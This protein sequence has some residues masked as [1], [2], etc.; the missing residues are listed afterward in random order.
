MA[1]WET[2]KVNDE[3]F[4]QLF[5]NRSQ[6]EID[7][8]FVQCKTSPTMGMRLHTESKTPYCDLCLENKRKDWT[9]RR[10]KKGLPTRPLAKCGTLAA[11]KRHYRRGEPLDR[12]CRKAFRKHC[13]SRKLGITRYEIAEIQG[14]HCYFCGCKLEDNEKTHIDHFYPVALGGSNSPHNLNLVC[15]TCNESKHSKDPFQ[16]IEERFGVTNG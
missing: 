7:P 8:M 9:E 2:Y 13:E 5:G 10:I 6:Y 3:E 14:W 15:L 1:R 4:K 11:A 12:A 16:W